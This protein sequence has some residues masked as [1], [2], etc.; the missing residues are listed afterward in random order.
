MLRRAIKGLWF[1]AL[2]LGQPAWGAGMSDAGAEAPIPTEIHALGQEFR[3]LRALPGHMQAHGGEWND[4][5][6]RYGGRKHQVMEALGTQLGTGHHTQAEVI[7]L[8][9]PPDQVTLQGK[10][11]PAELLVYFWRGAHDY[12]YFTVGD[13]GVVL[14][15]DWWMAGE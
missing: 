15:A 14:K 13:K 11:H 5:V 1:A 3:R 10:P 9:G 8:M 7:E 4:E 12:L 2:A 6:D